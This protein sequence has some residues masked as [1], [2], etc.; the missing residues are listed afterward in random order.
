[1][2]T[3][4]QAIKDTKQTEKYLMHLIS[5]GRIGY[6]FHNDVYLVNLDDIMYHIAQV[7]YRKHGKVAIDRAKFE[8]N[9]SDMGVTSDVI[10]F[11][12][13]KMHT[14]TVP[15]TAKVYKL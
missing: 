11:N 13:A 3:L 14:I 1:M 4:T 5:K 2:I 7:N 15:K 12:R 9:L 10:K 8:R 6:I